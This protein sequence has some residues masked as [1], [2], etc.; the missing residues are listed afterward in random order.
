MN[1]DLIAKYLAGEC[2]AS[3]RKAVEG[4]LAASEDNRRSFEATKQL[5]EASSLSQAIQSDSAQQW[6]QLAASLPGPTRTIPVWLKYAAVLIPIGF[7]IGFF[8]W[9]S[10]A[11]AESLLTTNKTG[12][13]MQ[14]LLE[15]ST[16]V[17]LRPGASLRHPGR[18]SAGSRE[19][20][21]TGEAYFHVASD[22][23]RP[24]RV[25]AGEAEIQVLGTE[26]NVSM[27]ENL[28]VAV[29]DG[30][31]W[32]AELEQPEN[33]AFL[34][35][36]E[37]AFL[38]QASG[39]IEKRDGADPN[40]IAWKTGVFKFDNSPLSTVCQYLEAYHQITIRL[41]PGVVDCPITT[42][43]DNKSLTEALQ[44]LEFTLGIEATQ[45]PDEVRIAGNCQ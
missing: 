34:R 15:D 3:E 32:V 37:T 41:E 5:W 27:D 17:W 7:C 45:A 13:P 39:Q 21:L 9:Q 33:R 2:E 1:T 20:E 42:V 18:F 19:V 44:I 36:N 23:T 28:E 30:K 26:F 22:S 24:F 14:L 8:F 4:W 16:E 31:V 40:D 43:L 6:E 29:F 12:S 11:T 38:S 35:K 25:V 10:R